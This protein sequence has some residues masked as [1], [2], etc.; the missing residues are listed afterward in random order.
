MRAAAA[1]IQWEEQQFTPEQ[2]AWI[3]RKVIN[4][5]RQHRRVNDDDLKLVLTGPESPGLPIRDTAAV[6]HELFLAAQQSVVIAGYAIY[7]GQRVFKALAQRMA[8][9][10]DLK[11]RMFLDVVLSQGH[12]TNSVKNVDEV[13]ADHFK[14]SEWP[15][16][17]PLPEVFCYTRSSTANNDR[18]PMH[19]KCVVVDGKTAFISSANFT[20][21]AQERNIE[22]GV[23]IHTTSIAERLTQHFEGLLLCGHFRRVL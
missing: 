16:G 6:V 23:L 19:A 14:T 5:R 8:K 3:I 4:D 7:H 17:Y 11:V 22:V 21:A 12:T 18:S 10:P 15:I 9:M 20:D 2:I 13:F 1:L